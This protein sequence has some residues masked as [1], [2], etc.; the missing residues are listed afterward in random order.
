MSYLDTYVEP[1]ENPRCQVFIEPPPCL[2]SNEREPLCPPPCPPPPCPPPPCDPCTTHV[3]I[4][5]P[6]PITT[7][8]SSST[9]VSHSLKF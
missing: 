8:S 6:S 5:P 9:Y 4:P 2:P 3:L 1:N 7:S